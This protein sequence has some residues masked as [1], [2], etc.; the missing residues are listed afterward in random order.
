MDVTGGGGLPKDHR[1]SQS[2][3]NGQTEGAQ[4]GNNY[5]QDQLSGGGSR[6]DIFK[7]Y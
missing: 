4:K 6:G 1:G 5:S 7:D 3:K 2:L